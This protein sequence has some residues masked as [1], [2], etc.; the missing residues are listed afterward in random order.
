M[1][2]SRDHYSYRVYADPDVARNFDSER[3]G[4]AIGEFIRQT[5]EEI[6]FNRLT[7]V[8]GWK[9][10][11]VGAGTGRV[12]IPLLKAGAEV[13]ACDASEEMLKVLQSKVESPALEIRSVDA[14]TLPFPDRSFQC[15][16]CLRLLMHVI[17]WKSVLSEL[18]RVSDDWLMIDFPPRHG[19]LLLTPIWHLIRS[20]F[21]SNVQAYRTIS[22]GHVRRELASHG[23]EIVDRNPGF[24]L[25]LVLHRMVGSQP[26]TKSTERFFRITGLTQIAGAPVTLFARRKK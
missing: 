12:T 16:I 3:F 10:I 4:G 24:F 14:H 18:C 13:T 1:K 21:A 23:F 20:V 17:D 7:D 9:V 2:Q 15:A 19:F 5:Q 11:D 22:I 8:K 25:P 26:F 6:L